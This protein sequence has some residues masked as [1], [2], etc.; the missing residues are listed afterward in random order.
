MEVRAETPA[1]VDAIAAVTAAAFGRAA[2]ADLVAALRADPDA[3]LPGLS[4]VAVDPA[5]GEVVGHV[6]VT[7]ARLDGPDGGP[8]A[9]LAPMAVAPAHQGRGVGSA[10]VRGALDAAAA[11]GERLVV[12]LGHPGYY[13]RFDFRPARPQGV[14]APFPV[15]DDVWLALDLGGDGPAPRGT[16][17]Y[18][19]AFGAV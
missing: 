6:L 3:W 14:E 9:A 10:L 19:R 7:R 15:D 12:V 18:P 13:P 4:L 5:D 11:R 17:V 16:V 1:D 8:V 2:E